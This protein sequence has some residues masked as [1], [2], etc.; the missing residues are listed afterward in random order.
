MSAE[1][2]GPSLCL[3]CRLLS[4]RRIESLLYDRIDIRRIRH[5]V[6]S[7]GVLILLGEKQEDS[8]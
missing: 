1:G 6:F 3:A 7:D 4:T 5:G 8:I 2:K